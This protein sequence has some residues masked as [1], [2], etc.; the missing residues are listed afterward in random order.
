MRSTQFLCAAAAPFSLVLLLGL[1]AGLA[2]VAGGLLLLRMRADRFLH[3]FVAFGAGFLISVAL[4][5]MVPESLRASPVGGPLWILAGFCG[6][7]LLEHTLVEH[8][9]FGEETHSHE[10]LHRSTAYSVTFG[11]AAHTFFDGIT[12]V[13]RRVMWI[14]FSPG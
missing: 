8:F 14:H 6:V 4:V 1:A 12:I 11:L 13:Q 5:E 10:F 7:H 2:N 3:G 9:H